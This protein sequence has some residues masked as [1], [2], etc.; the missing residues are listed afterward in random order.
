MPIDPK[1]GERPTPGVA[2]IAAKASLLV[3]AIGGLMLLL[4]RRLG[5]LEGCELLHA[6][7]AALCSCG[8]VEPRPA[9]PPC[10]QP[11]RV[12]GARNWWRQILE[13]LDHST[14]LPCS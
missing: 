6:A 14:Q 2:F 9:S 1:E 4:G 10:A 13:K 3:V 11:C 5:Q 8:R 7:V 12:E